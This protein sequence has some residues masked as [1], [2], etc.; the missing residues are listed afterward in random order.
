MA[1]E[2]MATANSEVQALGYDRK[3]MTTEYDIGNR[4]WEDYAQ[5]ESA[6]NLG[7]TDGE[8]ESI[9]KLL[10]KYNFQVV[11]YA[12]K[13]KL[14]LGGDVWVFID[15]DTKEVITTIRGK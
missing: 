15:T 12:P 2:I 3:N 10:K 7:S 5:S 8:L 11:Y 9:M 1:K 13:R 4:K 6:G 14:T